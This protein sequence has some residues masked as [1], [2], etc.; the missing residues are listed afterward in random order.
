[1]PLRPK[2]RPGPGQGLEPDWINVDKYT[3]STLHPSTRPNH[4]ALARTL[5]RSDEEGL[6]PIYSSPTYGKFL[7]LQCR[8]GQ[9]RHALD[10]GTLGGYSA[11]W[12][13]S[14]NPGMRVT[15]FEYSEHHAAVARRN[16]EDAGVADRIDLRVGPAAEN[17]PKLLEEIEAGAVERVGFTFIDAD[18]L[19]NWTYCDF[20]IRMGYPGSCI[21]IDNIVQHGNLV[22]EEAQEEEHVK[23][24]K[25]AI[26]QAGKDERIEAM[27]MQFVGERN[28]DGFLMAVVK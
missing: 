18:K 8:F 17:L 15:S 2:M 19:N 5:T 14:M 23:G 21:C 16:F 13:A 20:A 4:A 25:I 9:V 11:I 12:M 22:K 27:V 3:F 28:Y 6:P 24:A 10:V 7:A 26:E 1:M